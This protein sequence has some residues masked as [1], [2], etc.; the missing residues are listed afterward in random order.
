M[1]CPDFN[2]KGIMCMLTKTTVPLNDQHI[3]PPPA[4][5][6]KNKKG[7]TWLKRLLKKLKRLHLSKTFWSNLA[8]GILF[9]FNHTTLHIHW[10]TP[11]V[12]TAFLTLLNIFL[13][14]LTNKSLEDK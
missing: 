10:M 8:A 13:R 2:G 1:Q 11:Q 14:I 5:C 7:C 12:E 6:P 9:F 3:C 4:N